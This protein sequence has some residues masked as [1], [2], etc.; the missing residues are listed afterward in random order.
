MNDLEPLTEEQIEYIRKRYIVD[1]IGSTTIAK[2]LNIKAGKVSY[3]ISKNI[4]LRSCKQA[5]KQYECDENFFDLIDDE[6]K[7]YWLGFIYADGYVSHDKYS[8]KMGIALSIKD[9]KHLEKFKK[10]LQA[11][12][13]IKTYKHSPGNSY[14]TN[15]YCRI[16]IINDNIYNNLVKHGVVEHKTNVIT[17]P[18]INSNLIRHFIRGYFD[19]DGCI[20]ICNRKNSKK[21]YSIKILGTEKFLDMIKDFVES[22]NVAKIRKYYKRK[23]NQT[24][25]TLEFAGNYQVKHFLD[26]IYQDATIYLDRKYERY[27]NLCNLLHSRT[28]SKDNGLKSLELSGKPLELTTL[29]RNDEKNVNVNAKKK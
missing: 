22:N 12:N 20:S 28:L 17:P 16:V 9:I 14:G 23:Q 10:D 18:D 7:A 5:A 3:W 2:E 29:Q 25:S 8:K 15:D 21:E 1:K 11:E 6:H 26:I 19:G 4:G 13:P 24:V 27:L